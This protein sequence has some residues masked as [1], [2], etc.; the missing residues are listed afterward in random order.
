[1]RTYEEAAQLG[2]QHNPRTQ[3]PLL[4]H[5]LSSCLCPPPELQQHQC[6]ECNI[7][8][9]VTHVVMLRY[10]DADGAHKHMHAFNNLCHRRGGGRSVL[11]STSG[12]G[13]RQTC[14]SI[15]PVP[16]GQGCVAKG[17]GQDSRCSGLSVMGTDRKDTIWARFTDE[18]MA[19]RYAGTPMCMQKRERAKRQRQRQRGSAHT[20]APTSNTGNQLASHRNVL[21]SNRRASHRH[22]ITAI[23]A[24]HM[25]I[26]HA[27]RHQHRCRRPSC[28][29]SKGSRQ[30]TGES[31]SI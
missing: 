23:T 25:P 10:W 24:S 27:S 21:N 12:W 19:F 15:A 5:R 4:Q 14:R 28:D 9:V 30:L 16:A 7:E 18:A 8:P 3:A 29:T 6:G 20:D 22:R 2:R 26:M 13:H 17:T 31:N 11:E 1:M